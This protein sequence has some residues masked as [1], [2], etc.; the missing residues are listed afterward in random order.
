MNLTCLSTRDGGTAA[1]PGIAEIEEIGSPAS[2]KNLTILPGGH[3]Y[4]NFDIF[5]PPMYSREYAINDASSVDE[6]RCA[7]PS[8][9]VNPNT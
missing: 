5:H 7:K 6:P 4:D 2:D 9:P 8:S 1:A 3:Q